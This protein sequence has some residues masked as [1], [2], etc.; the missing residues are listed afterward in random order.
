MLF[1]L[2][3][4]IILGIGAE[5]LAWR[6]HLP[7]ILLLLVFGFVAG[8][9][10]GLLNPDALFGDLLLPI[11]SLAVAIIL[12]E[13]GL[14][15][16]LTELR[17]IGGVVRNLVTVGI[18]VSWLIGSAAAYYILNL[19]LPLSI[20][21]GAI[22]VVTGP[23]VIMPLLRYLRPGGQ[24]A[25][26]LKWE[27]III[28]PIGAIL[29]VLIFEIIVAG[30]FQGVTA[31]V[32]I[33]LLATLLVG[34][35]TGILGAII[36]VLLMRSYWIPDFLHSAVT[37]AMV[38]AVFTVSDIFQPESGLLA[39]TVM[40]ITLANQ[41]TVAIRHIIEFKENLRVL[42]ISSL[43]ILLASR[44]QV[45]NLS[46]VGII[47]LAFLGVL[48]FIAR[49]L[50]VALSTLRS[51]L[52]WR[53][54]LFLSSLAP[55]G[56]VAAA[57]SSVF[58]LQLQD[59]GYAQA[60]LLVPFTFVVVAG[61]V[62]IYGLSASPIA[63]GLKVAEP[64][65]QGVLIV[66]GH[67]WARAIASALQTE[68]YKVLIVDANWANISAARMDGLQTFYANILSQYA[69]DEIELGGIGRLLAL[70]YDDEFN[71]LAVLQFVNVFGRSESY[72]LISDSEQSDTKKVVSRHLHGRILFGQG[73]SYTE[74][75]KRFFK[76]ATMKATT[77]SSE[78]DYA[79]FQA[80]H[81]DSAIPLFLID[82]SG[83]LKMFTADT[84]LK[85]R[86]EQKIISI[87][88]PEEKP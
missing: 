72:Q 6:L 36:L 21:L 62:A 32:G 43:F 87:V 58:A 12:F 86:P 26:I 29:A 30:G 83:K 25:S 20:L 61:T 70:T 57:I 82:N 37:L 18:L 15:L 64:D 52:N 31:V 56:I 54:R 59:A 47:S 1:G 78:F 19:D 35:V 53:E 81:G 88:D 38:I 24:V 16:R 44:L 49:P 7:S 51:K 84:P 17:K 5:L 27:G 23:T 63:R 10:T 65:P 85:P 3:S 48:I 14:N 2:I 11:V 40:G 76:G 39:A 74:L 60:E 13:G 34:I 9:V 68:G 50:A 80:H 73:V 67:N 8:P 75:S 79:A 69:I 45:S 71:S 55:R 66:G 42:L 41:K 33:S 77:L 46:Q 22:L 4:I 28:D